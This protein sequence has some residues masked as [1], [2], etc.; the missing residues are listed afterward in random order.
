MLTGNLEQ[1]TWNKSG[2]SGGGKVWRVRYWD[3]WVEAMMVDGGGD[4]AEMV[5]V[6]DC[7]P[8]ILIDYL[9]PCPGFEAS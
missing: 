2:K 3:G 8:S 5:V 7:L 1:E 6:G 4:G 9:V